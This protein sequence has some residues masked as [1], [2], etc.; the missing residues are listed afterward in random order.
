VSQHLNFIGTFGLKS[1]Q[2]DFYLMFQERH[3]SPPPLVV[4]LTGLEGQ[5]PQLKYFN[6]CPTHLHSTKIPSICGEIP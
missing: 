2:G 1:S 5:C 6:K 4:L 3:T